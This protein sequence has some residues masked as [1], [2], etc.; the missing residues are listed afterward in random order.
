M[1][2][3]ILSRYLVVRIRLRFFIDEDMGLPQSEILC[4]DY[5]GSYQADDEN[6]TTSENSGKEDEGDN[7]PT[8]R[9]Q[10]SRDNSKFG[11][12]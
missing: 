2:K 5:G 4:N 11:E 10:W 12:R 1:W 8:Q 6:V 9:K 7:K 3:L